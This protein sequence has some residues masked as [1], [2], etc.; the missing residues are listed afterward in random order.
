MTLPFL[1]LTILKGS[2]L[3]FLHT[4]DLGHVIPNLLIQSDIQVWAES[5]MTTIFNNIQAVY[6]AR[7]TIKY[8]FNNLISKF[9]HYKM[10]DLYMA[11]QVFL[12]FG[13]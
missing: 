11:Q 1:D 5:Y 10:L 12:L 8:R 4:V 7:G 3:L 13:V 6:P 2:Q 9:Y